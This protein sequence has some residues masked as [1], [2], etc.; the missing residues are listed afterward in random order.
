V[1]TLQY[2][3]D[4]APLPRTREG[5][6]ELLRR[7]LVRPYVEK[8]ILAADAPIV[9]E[10]HRA[11]GDDLFSAEPDDSVGVVLARVDIADVPATGSAESQLFQALMYVS[12]RG[13]YPEYVAVRSV[14]RLCEVFSLPWSTKLP[15]V[16]LTGQHIFAGLRVIEAPNEIDDDAVV[17]LG[18]P[19]RGST[20]SELSVAAR[21]V[22]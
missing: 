17:V 15:E 6:I 13:M 20:L 11:P 12:Q 1:D 14:R 18:G 16:E 8:I 22:P 5:I 10:W 4:Q 7:I 19:V 2:T 21:F 9:V 3:V